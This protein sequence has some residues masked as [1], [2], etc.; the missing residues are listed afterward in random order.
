VSLGLFALTPQISKLWFALDDERNVPKTLLWA[1]V[2]LV[3]MA[4]IFWIGGLGGKILFPGIEPDTATV[5]ILREYW[6]PFISAFGMICILAAVMSTSAG[7][8]LIVAV[9]IAIDIYQDTIVAYGKK[10]VSKEI[11]DKRVLWMQRILIPLITIVGMLVAQHPPKFLTQLMWCG[12]GLFTGSVIP[13]MIVGCLWKGTTKVAAEVA[14]VTGF[15]LFLLLI[16]GFGQI[17]GVPF[18]KVPWTCAGI[19]TIVSF[20]LVIGL[21]FVTKPM[22]KEYVERLFAKS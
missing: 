15:V 21:S 4:M 9:A 17:M 3:F 1:F 19:S 6:P 16:F 10:K 5:A 12:I 20:V 8:F 13:P 2:A 22:T 11:M 14:S 7:L 18:F